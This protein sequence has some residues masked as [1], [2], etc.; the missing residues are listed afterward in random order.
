VVLLFLFVDAVRLLDLG[1]SHSGQKS[2]RHLAN[3]DIAP[4]IPDDGEGIG[5]LDAALERNA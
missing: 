5:R 4:R 2:T 3:P 1:M